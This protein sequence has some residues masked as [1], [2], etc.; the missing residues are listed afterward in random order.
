MQPIQKWFK[1]STKV[2]EKATHNYRSSFEYELAIRKEMLKDFFETAYELD[3]NNDQGVYKIM[4]QNPDDPESCYIGNVVIEYDEDT[5]LATWY[6]SGFMHY[7][8]GMQ[9]SPNI[10]VFNFSYLDTDENPHT[11][12]VAYTFLSKDV[13]RG[14]W[15]EEGYAEKGLEELRKLKDDEEDFNDMHDANFGFSLN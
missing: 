8:Y 3:V 15:I 14:E 9:V 6:I 5:W 7:A 13:V 10:L 11:G 2:T 4:G 1:N 12:L